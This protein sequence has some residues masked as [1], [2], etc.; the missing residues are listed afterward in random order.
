MV[1]VIKV[2]RSLFNEIFLEFL[3]LQNYTGGNPKVMML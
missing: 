2:D 1:E 3:I